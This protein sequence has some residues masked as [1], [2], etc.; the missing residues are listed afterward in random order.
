MITNYEHHGKQ[1]S[2]QDHLKGK[3][4]EHCLCWKG[5][6]F[7]EPNPN[8]GINCSI[9]QELFEFDCKHGVTTPVWECEKY[10]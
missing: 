5:C 1:V 6:K 7:F 2:V 4:R 9:A 3:H 10:E 8:G